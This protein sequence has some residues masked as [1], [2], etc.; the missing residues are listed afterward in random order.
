MVDIEQ[1]VLALVAITIMICIPIVTILGYD[2]LTGRYD[3]AL[4][5]RLNRRKPTSGAG[6]QQ[7]AAEVRRLRAA[8]VAEKWHNLRQRALLLEAYDQ[9][10]ARA[11]W[12]LDIEQQLGTGGTI[13][14]HELE[15]VRV[16]AQLQ[17]AGWVLSERRH[18]Q[19]A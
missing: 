1:V 14:D 7:A 18:D 15:R 12:M 13:L 9:A 16:E 19:A 11:C 3:S 10:L 17:D 4:E 6:R 8:V 5:R 2:Y